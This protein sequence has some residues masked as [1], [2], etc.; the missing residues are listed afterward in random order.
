MAIV[1]SLFIRY[2]ITSGTFTYQKVMPTI[3]NTTHFPLPSSRRAGQSMQKLHTSSKPYP[4]PTSAKGPWNGN[5]LSKIKLDEVTVP[6]IVDIE[7]P[8]WAN[9]V[10][11]NHA[12]LGA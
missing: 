5:I 6:N 7:D 4:L 8:M 9:P 10:T 11:R 2:D 3:A 12:L 1:A